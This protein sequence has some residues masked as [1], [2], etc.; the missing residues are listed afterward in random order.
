[1]ESAN[2]H[3]ASNCHFVITLV[4]NERF[5]RH[6]VK[7]NQIS[8]HLT[9][10]SVCSQL[11]NSLSALLNLSHP[12]QS[13]FK[14]KNDPFETRPTFSSFLQEPFFSIFPSSTLPLLSLS[15]SLSLSLFL[16]LSLQSSGDFENKMKWFL[17][18]Y[19]MPSALLWLDV[20]IYE[21]SAKN[22]AFYYFL[23]HL[24]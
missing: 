2:R 20:S 18:Y 11:M 6:V 8:M 3:L 23:F 5:L 14:R 16:V 15:L 7:S 10:W 1:M 21:K 22:C 17:E 13:P 4:E 24:L 9:L 12:A 19:S